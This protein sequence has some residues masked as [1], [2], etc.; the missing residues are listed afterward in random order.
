MSRRSGLVGCVTKVNV[1]V[2]CRCNVDIS[3][4][5]NCDHLSKQLLKY[6]L[7]QFSDEVNVH[8]MHLCLDILRYN[9]NS[10]SM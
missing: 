5:N 4:M 2:R 1:F 6:I 3:A 7:F 9:M 10:N 8:N